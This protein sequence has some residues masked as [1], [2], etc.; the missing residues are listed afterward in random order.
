MVWH[1]AERIIEDY[2]IILHISLQKVVKYPTRKEI[3]L[4][5]LY[6]PQIKEQRNHMSND[7]TGTTIAGRYQIE[8]LLAENSMTQVYLAKQ[9]DL[10]RQVALKIV[11]PQ[12]AQAD[13]VLDAFSR[14]VRSSVMYQ[15]RNIERVYECNTHKSTAFKAME[16]ISGP[17]LRALID[18]LNSQRKLLPLPVV[19]NIISQ[20]ATG[21]TFVHE[22]EQNPIHRDVTASNIMLKMKDEAP[23]DILQFVLNLNPSDVVLTDYISSRVLHDAIQKIAPDSVANLADY[24]S[25]EICHGK[26]GDSRADIYSLGVVLYELLT[27]TVPFP[28]GKP[29]VVMQK[30]T[31][32]AIPAPSTLRPDIPSEVEQVV[33]KAIAKNPLERF[34]DAEAFGMAVKQR[35]GPMSPSLQLTDMPSSIPARSA[36]AAPSVPKPAAPPASS[37]PPVAAQQ[38]T[39][40]SKPAAGKLPKAQNTPAFAQPKAQQ[41][42]EKASQKKTAAEKRSSGKTSGG[43]GTML[44]IVGIVV[45]MLVLIG[46][47]VV[48]LM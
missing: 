41:Q 6:Q 11:Q 15:H 30:H 43:G 48:F 24:M 13:G 2:C 16:F 32:E 7:L 19:G 46:A 44:M 21:L 18:E 17:T 45:V 8:E 37:A 38:A 20:V 23:D 9:P 39:P 25:P 5:G 29:S 12:L 22:Q 1:F 28:D 42:A 27:G 36:H 10:K 31:N 33:L 4:I 14:A 34:Y 40:S 26:K 47:I 35:M 3:T